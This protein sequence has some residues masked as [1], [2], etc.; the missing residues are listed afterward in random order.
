MLNATCTGIY[1]GVSCGSLMVKFQIFLKNIFNQSNL[2]Q[3]FSH[4]AHPMVFIE[5]RKVLYIGANQICDSGYKMANIGAKPD[6][7]EARKRLKR[8]RD[9][10]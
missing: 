4:L 1:F 5:R 2:T 6:N 9:T 8:R 10:P 3:F 7:F